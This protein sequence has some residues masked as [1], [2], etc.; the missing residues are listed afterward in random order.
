MAQQGRASGGWGA[1]GA[2]FVGAEQ[3]LLEVQVVETRCWSRN[4]TQ[5]LR[6][7]VDG[8]VAP[9]WWGEGC[10]WWKWET[11][12]LE[13]GFARQESGA[14]TRMSAHVWC[15]SDCALDVSFAGNKDV[16]WWGN[17]AEGVF[18]DMQPAQ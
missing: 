16:H 7:D 14:V 4:S 8:D 12:G 9:G 13:G 18:V 15:Q 1:R 6:R 17:T 2:V 5:T 10:W 11:V 3:Q